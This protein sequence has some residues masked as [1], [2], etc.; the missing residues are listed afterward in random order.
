M[1]QTGRDLLLAVAEAFEQRPETWSRGA[2]ARTHNNALSSPN[3]HDAAKFCVLG[4]AYRA[5]ET[6]HASVAACNVYEVL[7]KSAIGGGRCSSRSITLWNDTRGRTVA[8]VVAMLRK[9][10]A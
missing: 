1:I 9:A 4:A 6:G 10:A 8:E 3:C 5:V 2:F 7:F